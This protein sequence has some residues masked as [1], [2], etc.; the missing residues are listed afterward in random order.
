[1]I[2]V[3]RTTLCVAT[4]TMRLAPHGASGAEKAQ[5]QSLPWARAATAICVGRICL[6]ARGIFSAR[7][8]D[9]QGSTRT[10]DAEVLVE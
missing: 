7:S 9:K 3:I 2:E 6:R 5:R 10:F 8:T 1:M 4:R